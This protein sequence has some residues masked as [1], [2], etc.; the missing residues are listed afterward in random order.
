M[1]SWGSLR[2]TP[3]SMPS[4]APQ[5]LIEPLAAGPPAGTETTTR[6]ERLELFDSREPMPT[7]QRFSKCRIGSRSR[8]SCRRSH[9]GAT[10]AASATLKTKTGVINLSHTA[11]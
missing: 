2:F 5:A 4:P 8:V 1:G 6:D 10:A 9:S 7:V 3:G 11:E